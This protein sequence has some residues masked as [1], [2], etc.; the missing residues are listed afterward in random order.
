MQIQLENREESMKKVKLEFIMSN[1]RK[2]AMQ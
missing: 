1:Q 2:M